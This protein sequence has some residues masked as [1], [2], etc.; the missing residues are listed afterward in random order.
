MKFGTVVDPLAFCNPCCG[1]DTLYTHIWVMAC[2]L[3]SSQKY[4]RKYYVLLPSLQT[5]CC[6]ILFC[7][8]FCIER[9]FSPI[10]RFTISLYFYLLLSPFV[11]QYSDIPKSALKWM[12]FLK[13]WKPSSDTGFVELMYSPHVARISLTTW[14]FKV[15]LQH[16]G[17]NLIIIT[18]Q[19]PTCHKI[20]WNIKLRWSSQSIQVI[21]L[22]SYGATNC[23]WLGF[24][25]LLP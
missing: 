3:L 20:P 9:P 14:L 24:T 10:S 22:W 6:G 5:H 7:K 4:S 11:L 17:L 18:N 21:E 15:S 23:S 25:S 1:F 2:M 16:L 12:P 13:L 19:T 8:A